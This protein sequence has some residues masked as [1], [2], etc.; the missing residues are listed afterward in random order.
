MRFLEFLIKK[1][2][3][4]FFVVFLWIFEIFEIHGDFLNYFRRKKNLDFLKIVSGFFSSIFW[5]KKIRGELHCVF[6]HKSV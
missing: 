5:I 4:K 1:N 6:S 3:L 2:I